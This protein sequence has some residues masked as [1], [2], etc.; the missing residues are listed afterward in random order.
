M[1]QLIMLTWRLADW[2]RDG[3]LPL[4]PRQQP[5]QATASL[6][7]DPEQSAGEDAA[8]NGSA[9]Q[10]AVHEGVPARVVQV[11][12]IASFR[13]FLTTVDVESTVV[14]LTTCWPHRSVILHIFFVCKHVLN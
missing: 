14:N 10:H 6:R 2:Q 3:V 11:R 12:V 1:V 8:Y 4:Q 9:Q 5:R 13:V 7:G